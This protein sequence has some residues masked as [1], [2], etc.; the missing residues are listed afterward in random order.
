MFLNVVRN[1]DVFSVSTACPAQPGA[2]E[3]DISRTALDIYLVC[4]GGGHFDSGEDA[5]PVCEDAD[6]ADGGETVYGS[7]RYRSPVPARLVARISRYN[8][9]MEKVADS[10]AA[11][12]SEPIVFVPGGCAVSITGCADALVSGCV[13]D[14]DSCGISVEGSNARIEDSV[15][16]LPSA[17]P[18]EGY[19]PFIDNDSGSTV[20]VSNVDCI[21]RR[22]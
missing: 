16:T 15:I 12:L 9:S 3:W 13:I 14:G 11:Y 19:S 6:V 22:S 10:S 4:A 2:G 17:V 21:D 7:F 8:G 18:P 20:D 5:I 1:G